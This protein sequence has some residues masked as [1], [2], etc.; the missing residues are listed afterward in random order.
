MIRLIVLILF[1]LFIVVILLPFFKTKDSK[2]NKD[3][4]DKIISD[5]SNL[6]HQ[7]A[8]FFIIVLIIL[9][10]SILWLLPKF[11]INFFAI[12]Q[13]LIPKISWLRGILPF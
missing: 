13:K 4:A 12:L 6:G 10:A 3:I 7:N 1:I 9:L 2:K 5:Q 11:G 8:F